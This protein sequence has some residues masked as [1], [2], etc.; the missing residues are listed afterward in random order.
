MEGGDH[1]NDR[2]NEKPVVITTKLGVSTFFHML[3]GRWHQLVVT[4]LV[5]TSSIKSCGHSP[6]HTCS[7]VSNPDQCYGA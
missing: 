4:Y 7:K 1:K 6:A 3:R 2:K 5:F